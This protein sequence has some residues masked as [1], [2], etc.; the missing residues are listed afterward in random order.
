M[1]GQQH[2][3]HVPQRTCV[4]CR[5]V[6]AKRQLVRVVRSPAGRVEV[7]PTGKAAGRGAY[8]HERRACWEQ[9]L[10]R[11]TLDQAL[12]LTITDADRAALRALGEQYSD[13]DAAE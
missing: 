4:G 12:K 2:R 9:A 13:D 10:D 7:D 11:K 6:N 3:K 5:A 1:A 8:L